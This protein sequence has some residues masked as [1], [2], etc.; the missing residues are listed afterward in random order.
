MSIQSKDI[1]KSYFETGD[2]PSE[3]NFEDLIDSFVHVNSGLEA[4][5]HNELLNRLTNSQLKSGEK[6]LIYDYR[7][8]Q[9]IQGTLKGEPVIYT[10][11]IEPL[12]VLALSENTI[13][14]QVQSTQK[15]DDTIFYDAQDIQA[16]DGVTTT[17]GKI[18]RRI[19]KKKKA[20]IDM[21]FDF[22][23]AR[24][25]RYKVTDWHYQRP[26]YNSTENRFEFTPEYGHTDLSAVQFAEYFVEFVDSHTAN[27]TLMVNGI[28]FTFA[29]TRWK[30]HD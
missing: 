20:L 26:S 19:F 18:T 28:E 24:C 21:P 10:G 29:S 22:R 4:I 3:G 30:K 17:K 16:D 1:L 27:P 15:P 13:H 2:K 9:N 5:T 7:T 8:I 6:Y 23:A 11:D 14:H 12:I 25:R